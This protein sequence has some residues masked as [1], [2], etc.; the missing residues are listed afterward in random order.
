[1]PS[2][3]GQAQLYPSTWPT[4]QSVELL[5]FKKGRYVVECQRATNARVCQAELQISNLLSHAL[6]LEFQ[7][8]M[9]NAGDTDATRRRKLSHHIHKWA[10]KSAWRYQCIWLHCVR[11]R[12]SYSFHTRHWVDEPLVSYPPTHARAHARGLATDTRKRRPRESLGH[13]CTYWTPL[14]PAFT[15]IFNG[16]CA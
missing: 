4:Q 10:H 12:Y 14:C 7:M 1:M 8:W 15:L 3:R 13:T 16:S 11:L 5:G 6:I 2:R 9:L